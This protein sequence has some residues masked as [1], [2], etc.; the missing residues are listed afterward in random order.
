MKK[1]QILLLAVLVAMLFTAC[2]GGKEKLNNRVDYPDWYDIQDDPNYVHTFGVDTKM[3]EEMAIDGAKTNAF[4]DAALNVNTKVEGMI[5]KFAS[6]SGY[7][8]PEVNSF[9]NKAVKLIAEAEFSGANITKRE[10]YM[11]ETENGPR[12]KAYVRLSVPTQTINK[13]IY[14]QIS[15]EEAMY[16]EFKASQA[17]QELEKEMKN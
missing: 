16:N 2:G 12:F 7:Q 6:E 11:V 1:I 14:N 9:I 15:H 10:I 4:Y 3:S 8:N 17:F 5:K 13:N